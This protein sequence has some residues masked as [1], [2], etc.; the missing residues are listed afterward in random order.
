MI[1]FLESEANTRHGQ[2][3]TVALAQQTETPA[4]TETPAKEVA[5]GDAKG[6][7]GEAA[8]EDTKEAIENANAQDNGRLILLWTPRITESLGSQHFALEDDVKLRG[9]METEG[10][11]ATGAEAV[12]RYW[13]KVERSGVTVFECSFSN[14]E[15]GEIWVSTLLQMIDEL[16]G[17]EDAV[18]LTTDPGPLR[19]IEIPHRPMAITSLTTQENLLSLLSDEE[20][21]QELFSLLPE[22]LRNLD[23]LRRI[24]KCSA[25]NNAGLELTQAMYGGDAPALFL[26]LGLTFNPLM[27]RNFAPTF[28]PILSTRRARL[29]ARVCDF[30]ARVCDLHT[31]VLHSGY[32][33]RFFRSC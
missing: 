15:D 29:H 21:V 27:D 7:V 10:A 8:V 19:T 32:N 18:M 26:S 11:E 22:S 5:V 6:T 31:R 1:V 12:R 33:H 14:A 16:K 2:P 3:G 20:A 17:D 23:S 28:A 30:H 9:E 24:F 13:L 4:S 25:F